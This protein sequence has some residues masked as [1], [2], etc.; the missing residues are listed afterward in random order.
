MSSTINTNVNLDFR[1]RVALITGAARGQG[2]VTAEHM[3]SLGARV[4]LTDIDTEEGQQAAANLGDGATYLT[5]DV[6]DAGAW[7]ECVATATSTFQEA[8][9]ILINNAALYRPARVEEVSSEDFMSHIGVNLHGPLLG[10]QALL[11]A[12]TAAGTGSV[13]NV[14][15]VAGIGGFE[16]IV[17]YTASKW[18]LRGLTKACAKE[19]GPRGIR[20][21]SVI[22]GLIETRMASLN[23]AATNAA[24]VAESPLRRIGQPIEVAAASAFLASESASFITGAEIVVDGGLTLS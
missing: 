8:P 4:V 19:L 23:S 14:S 7:A 10:I 22:P 13:V 17:A 20:V 1:G 21:N 11:P 5:L 18:G 6:S 2:L 9:T 16:G 15:S 24:Y 3:L 12:M